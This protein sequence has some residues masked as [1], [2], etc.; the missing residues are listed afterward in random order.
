VLTVGND[1]TAFDAI[2]EATIAATDGFAV[3]SQ[4]REEIRKPIT[5][6]DIPKEKTPGASSGGLSTRCW[7]LK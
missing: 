1:C 4:Q 3:C 5:G 6:E 2:G 7:Y